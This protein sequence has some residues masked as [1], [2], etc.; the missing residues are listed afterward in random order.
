[1]DPELEQQLRILHFKAP[2][3]YFLFHAKP[4][5][6]ILV[7][8]KASQLCFYCL[9]FVC[10]STAE[11]ISAFS[12]EWSSWRA[13]RRT[14]PKR[15]SRTDRSLP[16]GARMRFTNTRASC[17]SACLSTASPCSRCFRARP[18]HHLLLWAAPTPRR[19]MPSLSRNGNRRT[20]LSGVYFLPHLAPPTTQLRSSRE[21]G[22]K[23]ERGMDRCR[24]R[25]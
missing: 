14:T 21:S 3:L 19:L 13:W 7:L 2:L 17:A 15:S 10:C 1:M 6:F 18:S 25:L 11:G 23:M 5:R 8:H 12:V 16:A 22:Q 24:G 9:Y 20:K 4:L